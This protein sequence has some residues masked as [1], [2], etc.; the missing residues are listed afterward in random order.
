MN[1]QELKR[2]MTIVRPAIVAMYGRQPL[3]LI[4]YRKGL[5]YANTVE[6]LYLRV[7]GKEDI[8]KVEVE[9]DEVIELSIVP[10]E[11]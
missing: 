6:R 7:R 1:E 10:A 9:G 4:E 2:I 3:N 11:N 8:Y 5:A